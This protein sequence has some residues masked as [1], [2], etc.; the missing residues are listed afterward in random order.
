MAESRTIYKVKRFLSTLVQFGNDISS[1]TGDRV[2]ELI[3]NLV[4]RTKPSYVIIKIQTI[5][6]GLS[7]IIFGQQFIF[8][9]QFTNKFPNIIGTFMLRVK[10]V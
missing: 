3:F 6:I 9:M 7:F 10:Q 8:D 1:E 5:I 2:K 4:V